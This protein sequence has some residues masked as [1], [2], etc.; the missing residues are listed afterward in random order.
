MFNI[1]NE[2]TTLTR[3]LSK[4]SRKSR[5]AKS[6]T[7]LS[8]E[9]KTRRTSCCHNFDSLYLCVCVCVD[10][11]AALG[12]RAATPPLGGQSDAVC[13]GGLA[14]NARFQGVTWGC[15]FFK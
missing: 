14:R 10:T 12:G 5:P 8:Q 15:C 13:P 9:S 3:F 7:R 4:E 6:V 11:T 1:V 2:S